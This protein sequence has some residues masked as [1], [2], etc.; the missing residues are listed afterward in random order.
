MIFAPQPWNSQHSR[1]RALAIELARLGHRTIYVNVPGS[2]AGIVRESLASVVNP[3]RRENIRFRHDAEM[4]EIWSPP[5]L[6]TFYRGSLTPGL[7]RRLFKNW[8]EKRIWKINAPIVA[9]IVM[10]YWWDG[11]INDFVQSFS[12]TVYDHKDPIGTYTRNAAI[13]R[14]MSEVYSDLLTQATGI[15]TH[16]GA[17]YRNILTSRKPSEVCLVRNAGYGMAQ[18]RSGHLHSSMPPDHPVIGTVGRIS[19]NID[20]QLLL[21][22]ADRFPGST[23]VN[24]GTV[25]KDTSALKTKKNI[26]LLPPMPQ[27]ELHS[28]IR[29]FDV[30]IL[31]YHANIEGSPLRVYDLLAECLQ[32]VS[33]KFPDSEYFKDVVH[34]A[35][36]RDEFIAKSSD[37]LTSKKIWI[38]EETI[39][40][41]MSANTWKMRGRQL[42][43]FCEG[44][45]DRQ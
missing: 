42:A 20:V 37:L 28:N 4:L 24:I 45:L 40:S 23:I 26:V 27:D 8:F 31:P 30:G 38:P 39:E 43:L 9:V 17:N 3:V 1:T 35:N 15:V 18:N 7:D 16:T 11:Y 44:L 32:V 34:I 22:L 21:D 19:K 29:R 33:T 12:A 6:P 5:T 36:N 2:L 41:F 14:R 13:Y 10:P 25:S